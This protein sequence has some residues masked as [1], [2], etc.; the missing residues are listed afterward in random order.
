M[1]PGVSS[2]PQV[3][4]AIGTLKS[5]RRATLVPVVSHHVTPVFI[6]AITARTRMPFRIDITNR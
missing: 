5:L 1:G 3:G 6:G 2:L 4:L